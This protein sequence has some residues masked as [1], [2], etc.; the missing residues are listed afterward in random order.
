MRPTTGKKII[1]RL[2]TTVPVVAGYGTVRYADTG[3]SDRLR[4]KKKIFASGP[5]YRSGRATARYATPTPA[6][7]TDYGEKKKF[8]PPD[9]G[10]G[11]GGLRHGTLRR[12]RPKRPTTGKKKNFRLRTTVPVVA[13]YGTVRYADTGRCDRLRGKK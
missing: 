2:R 7:A 5:R 3:R 10:T 4:G 6:E 8:S 1:F 13:G 12:H 11:R 9:H